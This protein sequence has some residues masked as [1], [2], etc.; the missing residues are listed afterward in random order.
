MSF[1]SPF[2]NSTHIVKYKP[3]I[4]E[5]AETFVSENKDATEKRENMGSHICQDLD[6]ACREI[7]CRMIWQHVPKCTCTK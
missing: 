3:I 5:L 2:M 6:A 4:D 1:V 7:Q